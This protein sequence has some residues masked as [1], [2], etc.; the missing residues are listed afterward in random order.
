MASTCSTRSSCVPSQQVLRDMLRA[1]LI[2][3]VKQQQDIIERKLAA[4][5]RLRNARDAALACLAFG[6]VT[7]AMTILQSSGSGASE[8]SSSPCGFG[9]DQSGVSLDSPRIG[10][11]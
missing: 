3:I 5:S 7:D 1:E 4:L 8:D 11:S 2:Q 10:G 9:R 6:N